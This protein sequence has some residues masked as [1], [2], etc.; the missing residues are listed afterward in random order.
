MKVANKK[1]IR[2]LAIGNMKVSK[3]RNIISIIAIVL[4][5]ILF[6][7]IFTIS[8]SIIDG[9]EEAGFRRIGTYAHGAFTRL[10][11]NQYEQLAT[12]DRF[13]EIGTRIH[14][15]TEADAPLNKCNV[16]VSYCDENLA[17][18]MYIA[19]KYGNLPKEGTNEA[20][21]DTR[22]LRLLG[23]DP[24]IGNEFTVTYKVNN[25]PVTRT[26]VLSGYWAND[27]LAPAEH[28]LI[29]KSEAESVC[30]MTETNILQGMSAGSYDLYFMVD[31]LKKIDEIELA[32]LQEN[33]YQNDTSGREDYIQR[34]VNNGYTV[35]KTN[36][37]DVE[38]MLVIAGI[39]LL[40]M[41]VGYLVINNIFS[42]SISNDIQR[43]GLLK[44]IGTTSRQIRRIVR[45]ESLL[46]AVIGIPIGLFAGY[47]IGAH[48]SPIVS[49]QMAGINVLVSISPWIFIFSTVFSLIT[50][51]VSSMKPA[52]IAAKSSP[53]AAVRYT[54]DGVRNVKRNKIRTVKVVISLLL[55][56]LI[57]NGVI[58]FV[59]GFNVERYLKDVKFDYIFA[60]YKYF[61]VNGHLYS[62]E[63]GV[64]EE[65]IK[66]IENTGMVSAGGRTYGIGVEQYIYA[67]MPKKIFEQDFL[68]EESKEY[69]INN[70]EQINGGYEVDI[71]LYGMDDY[72]IDKLDCLEGDLSLLKQEGNIAVVYHDVNE[73][74]V[75]PGDTVTLRYVYEYDYY[76]PST[77]ENYKEEELEN[78]PYDIPLW[79]R[80]VKYKDVTY[81]VCA[82]VSISD[83]MSYRYVIWDQFILPSE[84]LL[85]NYPDATVMYYAYDVDDNNISDME[86]YISDYTDNTD[87]GYESKQTYIDGLDSFRKMFLVLGGILS[88]IIALIGVMN[89]INIMITSV[90]ARRKE[91]A[92]LQ[93]VGMTGRQLKKMLIMEG[94]TYVGASIIIGLIVSIGTNGI[95]KNI[96]ENMFYFISY[97]GTPIPII[98]IMPIF[99]V[100][101]ILVPVIAYR[102]VTKKSV[103]ERLRQE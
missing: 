85:E 78:L 6:T 44:T 34:E 8:M 83:E 67:Y 73:S 75:K 42:I 43:Y 81:N 26:Y 32:V 40:V 52:R 86:A 1:C 10:Y 65:S 84:E 46:L 74:W 29:S 27:P 21:T 17:K 16:E 37:A 5:T 66:N 24:V 57:F 87:Y 28:I 70:T 54:E 9:F 91:L 25:I 3:T 97:K 79:R 12:D 72:C 99:V 55:A 58:N 47:F 15:G 82:T 41:I 64:M 35:R 30:S 4:T 63:N 92:M 13:K 7:S 50:V 18:W 51:F 68:D 103:V 77:G 76:N 98:C 100:I 23:V 14:V 39:V 95:V 36:A 38:T 53:V 19:P 61:Q 33:G 59:N 96:A 94:M 102:Q 60:N 2:R 56:I 11:K 88:G 101:G 22:L 20:A 71:D 45:I 31:N 69:F 90:C 48:L 49:E 62:E 93:A 89:F 80:A